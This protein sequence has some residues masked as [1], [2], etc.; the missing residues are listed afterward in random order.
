MTPDDLDSKP[1]RELNELF[2]V[3]V[4]GL[5]DLHWS[6]VSERLSCADPSGGRMEVPPFST[7]ADAV[8]TWLEKWPDV[9]IHRVGCDGWQVAIMN[10]KRTAQ[11]EDIGIV[12]D[13][14]EATFPLAAT[15]ALIRAYRAQKQL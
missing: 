2:A 7:S 14:W 5:T 11:G 8:L 3:E 4:A 6:A 13:T 1:E 15:K 10:V 12:S 9:N